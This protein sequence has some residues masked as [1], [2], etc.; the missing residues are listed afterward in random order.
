MAKSKKKQLEEVLARIEDQKQVLKAASIVWE[1][2]REH[3][4]WLTAR[5]EVYKAEATMIE[6]QDKRDALS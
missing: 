3:S 6:L 1:N 2:A 5:Q 4:D